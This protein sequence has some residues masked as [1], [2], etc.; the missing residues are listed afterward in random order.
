[1][2]EAL[3]N[4]PETEDFPHE[5]FVLLMKASDP[6]MKKIILVTEGGMPIALVG[7]K[8]RWGRW[9]PVTQWIVPGVLFP[10]KDGYIFR[11]LAALGLDVSVALWRWQV[12]P[13]PMGWMTDITVTPTYG[14]SCSEDFE[15]YW[16]KSSLLRNIRTHRNRCKGFDLKI[17]NP[18]SSGLIIK[19]WDQKWHACQE[20]SHSPDIAERLLAAEYLQERGLHYSLLLL[21]RDEPV[22]G[23]TFLIHRNEAVSHHTYRN[24]QYDWHGVMTRVWD[25]SF[26]WARE[27]GFDGIDLGGSFDYKKPWAPERGEKW[28]FTVR[29]GYTSF[30][31]RAYRLAVSAGNMLKGKFERFMG[32]GVSRAGIGKSG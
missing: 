17:N 23:I 13:P 1:M 11:V 30:E 26:H 27:M 24:P 6:S 9:M 19:N 16:R 22:A 12:L 21:D 25:L 31:E 29:P 14:M 8:Y 28:E 7:L 32:G 5:L 4:L 2:D 18:N 10:A 20:G 15:A 3:N